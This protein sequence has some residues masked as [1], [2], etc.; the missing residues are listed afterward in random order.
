MDTDFA[1]SGMAPA[2]NI[3]KAGTKNCCNYGSDGKKTTGYDCLLIPGALKTL[4]T[5]IPALAS[6][7]C[8]RSQGIG[9]VSAAPGK[10]ICSE[11]EKCFSI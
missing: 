11:Y 3:L 4:T 9:T 10:T 7:F 6:A 1:V 5:T 8:G 2:Q